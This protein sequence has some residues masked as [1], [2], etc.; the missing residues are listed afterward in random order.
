M[1][2]HYSPVHKT[3]RKAYSARAQTF[4]L[5]GCS[6]NFTIQLGDPTKFV[7]RHLIQ[8]S[9]FLKAVPLKEAIDTQNQI[10]VISETDAHDLTPVY[11]IGKGEIGNHPEEVKYCIFNILNRDQQG[12][13]IVTS[14]G[15]SKTEIPCFT[16]HIAS[17]VGLAV[18]GVKPDEDK[19]IIRVFHIFDHSLQNIQEMGKIRDYLQTLSEEGYQLSAMIKGGHSKYKDTHLKKIRSCLQTTV[20][21]LEKT[22]KDLNVDM[23]GKRFILDGYPEEMPTG[24]GAVITKNPQTDKK[25]VMFFHHISVLA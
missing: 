10:A 1:V 19:A 8:E 21:F 20:P 13:A 25:K 7:A 23:Q 22:G 2:G 11:L 9:D 5:P 24:V 3:V 16:Q 14:V 18:G 17:C 12:G 6:P 4:A 15:T